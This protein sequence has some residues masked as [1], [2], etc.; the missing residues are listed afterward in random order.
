MRILVTGGSGSVGRELVPALLEAGHNVVVLDADVAALRGPLA[1]H[2]RL[3]LVQGLVEDAVTVEEVARA[4]DAIVHL[5]WSFADEPRTLFE[6]DLRAHHILL[7]AATAHRLKHFVYASTAVVYGKPLRAPID[8]DHPLRVLEAR[9]PAYGM[10]KDYAEK[11]TL[12]AGRAEQ[13]P[14]T[15]LRFW[16]AFGATI[17]GRHLRDMLQTAARGETLQV[18]ADCGGSFLSMDDLCRVVL[19]VLGNPAASGQVFNVGS[20]Y[21]TWRE[22]AEMVLRTTGSRA[23]VEVV[24]AGRW[25]GA[26][27][28]ANRWELDDGRLRHAL[29]WTPRGDPAAVRA[30]LEQAIEGTWRTL[31]T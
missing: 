17:S 26:A 11:L 13:L 28:L 20:A 16:W 14:V 23:R 10:A 21:V 27:F 19:Q 3:E 30:R 18:P 25:T 12:L 6:R 22:V 8:E 9:K 5:A 4:A 29:A 1:T 31:R 7:S 2:A 15:I 24:P